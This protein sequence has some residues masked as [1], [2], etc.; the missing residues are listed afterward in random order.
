M[1]EFMDWD[2]DFGDCYHRAHYGNTEMGA[3]EDTNWMSV[4]LEAVE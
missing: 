2:A 3:K 1:N 4:V